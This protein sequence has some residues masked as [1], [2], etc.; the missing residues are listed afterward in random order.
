MFPK[1]THAAHRRA[2]QHP[3][4]LA[5]SAAGAA[6]LAA[7]MVP[8]PQA[9][10][11]PLDELLAEAERAVEAYN[12]L[13]ERV[14]ELG[15]EVERRQ[16]QVAR[17]QAEV[18]ALRVTAG[19]VAAAQYRSGGTAPA[20]V[21]LLS[22]DPEGYLARAET[23]ERAGARR[24]EGLRRL[25]TANAVLEQRREQ[26][27]RALEQLETQRAE[28]ARRK[29]EVQRRLAAAREAYRHRARQ[30]RADRAGREGER[31]PVAATGAAET[32][33]SARA[34]AAV[35]AARRAVGRPYAWGQN[36]PWGF[37][38]SG[39]TQWAWAQA[40]VAL[41]RTSQAQATAGERVPLEQ[42][43]PGDLVVYRADASHVA[44]YA[45]GG[46]VIHAP[47]PG[48][49]VRPD[50]VGMMPVTAVVRP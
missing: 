31:G 9:A 43:R 50:P 45:G 22:E 15:T 27:A 24:A 5:L 25:H 46:Q 44:L 23:L 47:Y 19:A 34:G 39:L 29:T 30:D 11:E 42:A 1:R 8:G 36:G 4:G 35:A 17:G 13:Q 28:L 7:G 18:N 40:G 26:A 16:D 6:A 20:L 48:A 14:G 32:A 41:P 12:A 38:C 49:A 21:L 33:P 3:R 37:D 2:R 10:A